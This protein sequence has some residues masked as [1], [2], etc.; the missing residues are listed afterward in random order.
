M[1]PEIRSALAVFFARE[2]GP[3]KLGLDSKSYGTFGLEQ[4]ATDWYQRNGYPGIARAGGYGSAA[5]SGEPVSVDTALNH[6]VVWAC[7]RI[8]SETIG[9][10]PCLMMQKKAGATEKRQADDHPMYSALKNAPNEEMTAAGFSE[11]LTSHCVLRGNAYA[12]IARRSGTGVAMEMYPVHPDRVQPGR[13][14]SGRLV[15][16]VRNGNFGDK[17]FTVERGKPHDIFHM[18]G[19]G[20]DG[21]VGYSVLH[22]ARQSIGTALAAERNIASFYKN[23]GRLPYNL[24]LNRKLPKEDFD[25]FRRD[26]E[27]TYNVAG[28]VPILEDWLNYEQTGISL[29][30]S[31]MLETRQ[32]GIPEICRWFLVSP[33]LVGDLSRA[34][35]ANIEQLALEFVKLTLA[36]WLTRWEQEL[37]RCVLTK[38]EKA[39]GYFWR[40]NLNALLR[41]DFATRMAGYSTMLQNGI[42]SQNEVRDLEDWNPVDGGDQYHIQLNMQT[43]PTP[44][45][46]PANSGS[47]NT[48]V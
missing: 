42:A 4:I 5:W 45:T 24:K 23:G 36:T 38:Q 21:L 10:L 7:N 28:R 48:A 33:H 1:L 12:Q 43:L 6:S 46:L 11:T 35:F 22:K 20:D 27:S 13:D 40:H 47:T 14:S 39:E 26:W 16:E 18:R 2:S 37:W 34:T 29:K 41:G 15:Y 30:D 9:F 44:S 32:F 17:T 19:I 31:Q 8:I 25:Q 3:Q